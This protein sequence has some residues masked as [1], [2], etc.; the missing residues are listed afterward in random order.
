[1]VTMIPL[2]VGAILLG[3]RGG[4]V[5]AKKTILKIEKQAG[6]DVEKMRELLKES[7]RRLLR[8]FYWVLGV[9]LV[10]LSC[11]SIVSGSIV[12]QSVVIWRVYHANLRIVGPFIPETEEKKFRARFSAVKTKEDFF[13]IARDLEIIARKN[14]TELLNYELW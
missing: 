9:Y 10:V 14:N 3:V 5:S 8:I 6:E 2:L 1:M 11:L 4:E 7:N 13:A 12:N